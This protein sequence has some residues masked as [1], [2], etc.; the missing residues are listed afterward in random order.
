MIAAA[1]VGWIATLAAGLVATRW[2]LAAAIDRARGE[3]SARDAAVLDEEL[4]EI[5]ESVERLDR[6]LREHDS[7]LAAMARARRA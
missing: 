1:L 4:R 5:R 7:Q 2:V 3:R 6:R